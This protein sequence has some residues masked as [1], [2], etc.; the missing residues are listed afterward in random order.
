MR[1]IIHVSLFVALALALNMSLGGA[2]D[3]TAEKKP[4]EPDRAAVERARKTVRMLDDIY[5]TA[6]VLI[7]DKYVHDK[8]D[9]PAGRA[10]VHWFKAISKKGWH[11][12]RIIDATGEPYSQANVARDAFDKEGIRRLKAGSD[13]YDQVETRD[14]KSYL[15]AIT[16]VPVVMQKCIMCHEHY[17]AAKKG[18]P[19]GALTY[20]VPLD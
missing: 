6:V 18:E 11:E 13:F 7:T 5:K 16:P 10:A 9:F 20:K 15:R 14:G 4:A 17:K 12:I 8:K 1:R 19:V 2:A 3:S